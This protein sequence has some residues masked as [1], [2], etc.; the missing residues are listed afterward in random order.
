MLNKQLTEESHK[1]Y[2][3]KFKKGKVHSPFTDNICD[4]DLAVMQLISKFNK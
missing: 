2:I 3:R 1:P 4:A